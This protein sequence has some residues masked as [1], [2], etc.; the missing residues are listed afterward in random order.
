MNGAVSR[1]GEVYDPAT[2]SWSVVGRMVQSRF[3]HTASLLLDGRVLIAGG[4]NSG[5]VTA[6][7]EIFDPASNVFTPVG[8]LSAPRTNHA[9]AVLHD[10][11]VLIAGGSDGN[12]ALS[13]VDIFDPATGSVSG[14]PN[15]FAFREGPSATTLLDGKVLIV[16]GH[17][18]QGDEPSADIYDPASDTFSP[19]SGWLSMARRDHLAFLLPHNNNVLI[20]GGT[21]D[22]T[23]LSST[24]L[25]APWNDAFSVTGP[26]SVARARATGSPL[27]VDGL[28]LAAGGSGST[29][30]ELYGFATLKTDKPDYTPGETV[31]I[32]GTGWEPG[33]TVSLLLQEVPRT[34]EERTLT[35]TADASGNIFNNE[36]QPEEHDLGVRFYLTASGQALQA[37]TTFTDAPP[38]I[39][40]D[41]CRNG[42]AATPN[43][44]VELGGSMGWVNGNAGATQ[45]HYIEG[46]SVPYRAVMTDLPT[47]TSITV[48]LGYDITH[49]GKHAI[50]YL[51]HYERLEPH[52]GFGHPAETV[53]PTSGVSGVS[54]TTTTFPIPA[55]SSAGS[56]VAGQPTTSFNA[57]PATERVMTLFGGTITGV[58]YVSEGSLTAS[59]SETTISITF[60]V[61]SATA[62][63][64]WGGHI[65]KASDWGNGNS[66]SGIDGSPYHMRLIDWTLGNLGN[67]DRSLAAGAVFATGTVVITKTAEGGDD[68]FSYTGTGSGIPSSFNITTVGGTESQ[69]FTDILTGAKTVTESGP[70]SGWD[71]TSLVCSDPDSETTTSGQTANIDLDANETVSCTFTN[72][73]QNAALAL[74]KSASPS[75][76]S[77]VGQVITY[78]YTIANAGNVTLAGPFSISDDKQG[79]ISP[80]GSGPLAPAASTSCTS[81]HT[82][83]QADLDAGS[84]KNTAT[85]SGNGVTSPEASATVTA[86]RTVALT[87]D[88]SA[89]PLTYDAVGDVISYSYLLTNTGSVTLTGPF[90]VSDDRAPV[91]VCPVTTLILAPGTSTTCMASY[92]ITQAD[93]NAG[94]VTNTAQGHGFFGTTMV[95]SNS[96]SA[97]VTAVQEE[98]PPGDPV[99]VL[100]MTA[101]PT[102]TPGSLLPYRLDYANVG[103]APSQSARIVDY[104]PLGVTFVSATNGG[105]YNAVTRRVTWNLGTVP[106]SMGSVNLVVRVSLTTPAG[107]VLLNRAEFTG[108]ATQSPPTAQAATLVVLR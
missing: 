53:T 83:T 68:T 28:F 40:L 99:V 94:S 74:D 13:S 26:M 20:V 98:P 81:T 6:S 42:P 87:L 5:G 1:S 25:Y 90:T 97:T 30:A 62:V 3:G 24:E 10:G 103:P 63:L 27:A 45:A 19:T 72:T 76:Y 2:N 88:K 32:T 84:I 66:A 101:S 52:A 39:N 51:T 21:A 36:F 41:Q 48:V 54:A 12:G 35:A 14:G 46:Y 104:L 33:E 95:N 96:D 108:L 9:A 71:F 17:G 61:S 67:Q 64:A 7:L 8:M 50:D 86:V 16:G 105:T 15:L 89:S 22:G 29:G 55:P 47:A 102:V 106:I 77:A 100:T 59:Q 18:P 107:T 60:T 85:A 73:K 75:T 78:T 56:P 69:T 80:C 31:I 82:I 49:S 65:A 57:L 34:H 44:C 93:L 37:Q 91:V 4:Q 38:K 79:T 43:D 58:S 70:P 92:H 23:D 11:R